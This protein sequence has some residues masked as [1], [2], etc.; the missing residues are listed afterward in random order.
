LGFST[1]LFDYRGFGRSE[2]KPT[3]KGTYLDSL[4]AWSYLVDKRSVCPEE[5]V[6]YGES[7]GGAVGA[8]LAKE[9]QPAALVLA[10]SFTSIPDVAASLYPLFPVRWLARFQ[11]DTRRFISDVTCPILVIHSPDDEIIPY[12]QGC[13]LFEH[14]REPRA[15]LEIRGSHNTGFLDSGDVYL[16]GINDFLSRHLPGSPP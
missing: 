5:I 1:F 7:L 3:E 9:R 10:S 4:G 8:W 13:L 15:F 6:I 16:K 2:G 11:Y 14:A 12:A